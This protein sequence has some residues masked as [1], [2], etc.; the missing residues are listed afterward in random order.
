MLIYSA[1][2]PVKVE[3]DR[4]KFIQM[5]ITWNQ[6]SHYDKIPNLVWD[7]SENDIHVKTDTSSFTITNLAEES[8]IASHFKKNDDNDIIW[9]TDFVLDYRNHI[10]SV[11]LYRETTNGTPFLP[12]YK[13]PIFVKQILD[14]ELGG[15]DKDLEIKGQEV[16]ITV[17]NIC[18]LQQI[19]L[20]QKNYTLPV[21]YISKT[22]ENEYIL[23]PNILAQKLRGVAH[24]V[25]ESD[26]KISKMLQVTTKGKNPYNGGIGVYFPNMYEKVYTPARMKDEDATTVKIVRLVNDYINQQKID[27]LFM[28][29][30]IQN[31]KLQRRNEILLKE[32]EKAD[33]RVEENYQEFGDLIDAEQEHAE[34]L[35]HTI[36]ALTAENRGLRAK[37]ESTNGVAILIQGEEVEYYPGELKE[38]VYEILNKRLAQLAGEK[39]RREKHLLEDILEANPINGE[40]ERRRKLIKE[41]LQGYQTLS[42]TIN[43]KLE[44]IGFKLK[45]GNKHYKLIYNNDERYTFTMSKTGSDNR[46]GNNLVSDIIKRFL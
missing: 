41:A 39:N 6:G 23:N 14:Q 12:D 4:K 13:P 46:G 10:I 40:R 35:Q 9:S 32:K 28:W 2:F 33:R 17:E 19:I 27:D 43:R 18:V 11:Q 42:T 36:Q 3:L 37:L 22:K 15:M 34:E 45:S 21:I 31:I 25:A 8:I 44:E 20:K 30:G 7:G 5:A 1:K 16:Y 29:S 24:V 38:L 26:N